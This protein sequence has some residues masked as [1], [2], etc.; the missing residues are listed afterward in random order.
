MLDESLAINVSELAVSITDNSDIGYTIK[1]NDWR[2]SNPEGYARWFEV[3]MR[4]AEVYLAE[5]EMFF[6][7]SIDTLPYYQWKTPLQSA[8]QL[9]KT[10]SRYDV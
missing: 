2:V 1:T 8:V 4:T 10:T 7:A 9:L 3:R 5:R 6:K